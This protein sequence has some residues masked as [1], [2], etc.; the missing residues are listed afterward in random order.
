MFEWSSLSGQSKKSNEFDWLKFNF[1]G[2][3][4]QCEWGITLSDDAASQ[5]TA[6]PFYYAMILS[7]CQKLL[8]LIG[9]LDTI[10][11]AEASLGHPV[12]F[13]CIPC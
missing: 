1:A 3:A 5:N 9:E 7:V 13:I 2:L 10:E 12:L 11:L 4:C 8:V 6:K